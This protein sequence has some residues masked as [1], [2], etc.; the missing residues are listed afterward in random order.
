M[1]VFMID[2]PWP[3]YKGGQR[4][5]RPKQ[6]KDLDYQIMS[7][8]EI[9]KLLDEEI[10]SQASEDHCVFMWTI[11]R[12]LLDCD[13][14]M[15]NRGYKRHVVLIWDKE[16]GVAPAF[17]VR[18]S[19]EYL[20]WYYKEKLLPINKAMRGIYTTVFRERPREHS[21]KPDIAYNM[22]DSLYPRCKKLDVFSREQ[23]GGWIQ[24]GNES[25]YFE[26]RLRFE[27]SEEGY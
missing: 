14:E 24:F 5:V 27:D 16:N 3:L 2:P 17:T 12:F 23:R 26:K 18:F 1:D 19:H 8:E 9:F 25:D 13:R 10:L 4:K 7:V 11:D 21:R 6:G 22:I 20:V 15:S